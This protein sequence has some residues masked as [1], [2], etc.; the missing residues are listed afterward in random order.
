MG[1]TSR[2]QMKAIANYEKENVHRIQVKVF[3]KDAD[4][5]EWYQTKTDKQE[6]VR[7]L[8]REDM[9]RERTNV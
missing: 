8:I 5:W 7:G 4:L 6:Y 3:P 1:T 2:A 9:N